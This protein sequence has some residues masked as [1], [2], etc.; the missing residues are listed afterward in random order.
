MAR[1]TKKTERRTL[2]VAYILV[3]IIV[4]SLGGLVLFLNRGLI[5]GSKEV[6]DSSRMELPLSHTVVAVCEDSLKTWIKN[7]DCILYKSG[8]MSPKD[9]RVGDF[10]KIVNRNG[11]AERMA[12][13]H[14]DFEWEYDEKDNECSFE[15]PTFKESRTTYV[16][17]PTWIIYELAN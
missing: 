9:K 1:D 7:S 5:T 17:V 16:Y 4:L 6:A 12:E 8:K 2:I 11:L 10:M 13:Y 15:M 3:A 14:D